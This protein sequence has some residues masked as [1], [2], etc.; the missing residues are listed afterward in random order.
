MLGKKKDEIVTAKSFTI[1]DISTEKGHMAAIVFYNTMDPTKATKATVT[2]WTEEE[3]YDLMDKI[4]DMI[5][6]PWIVQDREA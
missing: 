5:T 4:T 2:T 1:Q 3:L 6:D